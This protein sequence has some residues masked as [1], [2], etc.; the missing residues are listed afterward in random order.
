MFDKSCIFILKYQFGSMNIWSIIHAAINRQRQNIIPAP[1]IIAS[2]VSTNPIFAE[3][4]EKKIIVLWRNKIQFLFLLLHNEIKK[5]NTEQSTQQFH[6]I[7]SHMLMPF[8]FNKT[9]PL[10]WVSTSCLRHHQNKIAK[11]KTFGI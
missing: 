3:Q 5:C 4:A 6:T 10:A 8:V 2:D 11:I 1:G 7:T 9:F